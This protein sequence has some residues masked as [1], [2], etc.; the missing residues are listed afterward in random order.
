MFT[1]RAIVSQ[2]A[3][4]CRIHASSSIRTIEC[5][6][7]CTS[8]VHTAV[9][10]KKIRIA[11]TGL[12]DGAC[13]MPRAIAL[14]AGVH[15][16]NFITNT[17]RA[18]ISTPFNITQTRPIQTRPMTRAIIYTTTACSTTS[19]HIHAGIP[20]IALITVARPITTRAMP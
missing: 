1:I 6:K 9:R 15:H 8:D 3:R 12:I 7:L 14:T 2:H 20:C 18:V 16:R 19:Q 17:D 13:P 10:A 11:K 4:T 5:A